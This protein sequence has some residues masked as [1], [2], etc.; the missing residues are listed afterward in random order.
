MLINILYYIIL[1]DYFYSLI[2]IFRLSIYLRIISD[3]YKKIYAKSLEDS[4]LEL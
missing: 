3:K 1:R 2:Y 4:L